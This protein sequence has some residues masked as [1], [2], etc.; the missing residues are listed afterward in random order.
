MGGAV[1][2]VAALTYPTRVASLTLVATTT[3][4]GGPDLPDL[5]PALREYFATRPEPDWADRAGVVEHLVGLGRALSGE[6]FDEAAARSG[7]EQ[8]VARSPQ[9]ESGQRNHLLLPRE[10]PWRP[11]LSTLDVAT[12]VIHGTIDPL[13]PIEHGQALA[14]EIPGA[15]LMTVAGM[16]HEAPPPSSWDSVI[17]AI[18]RHTSGGWDRQADRLAARALAA[19]DPTGWF[20]PLYAAGVA[21]EVGLPWDTEG[22]R[23]ALV[24]WADGRAGHG[25]RAL[26]VGC[27]LGQNSEYIA[28]LGYATDAF[29]ISATAIEVVRR[30][31]PD[32]PV[33]YRTADLFDP[34]PEWGHVFDLVVEVFT[35]QALPTDLRARAI[36]AVA[37]FT[38]PGGTLIVIAR[39]RAEDDPPRLDPPWPLTQ[40]E[41][42]SFTAHGLSAVRVEELPGGWWR[43]EFHRP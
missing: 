11:R 34:P 23:P 25:R 24:D 4:P 41:I 16:G 29:D 13:F 8:T 12:L 28:G 1:A 42:D 6:E 18:L 39:A 21:G 10:E 5:T 32:S 20:E 30:R 31:F 43:A 27:G 33:G 9:V 7:F 19:G 15:Q 26:V 3:G 14:D 35:V 38:A 40:A 2:L 37:G 22:P 17:P 36:A